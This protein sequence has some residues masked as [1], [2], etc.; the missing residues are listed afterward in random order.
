M[1]SVSILDAD[2]D[3]FFASVEQRDDARLRGRPVIVGPGVVLA[4]SYEAR[5]FGVRSAMGAA[6]A[7][8]LCPDAVVVPARFAAYVEASRAVFAIFDRTAPVV[9]RL[10]I[11]EA[12]LDVRGLE[13]IGGT[14]PQ[15]ARRLRAEVRSEVGLPISVGV[16]STKHLAKV[17]SSAAKPDGLLVIE[18][19]RELAF[20][21]PLPVAR[22]WGVGPST[23]RRL[24]EHGIATVGQL[25]GLP[26]TTVMA[27]L[28][29]AAGSRLHAIAHNR[30]PRRVRAERR[31]RSFGAQSAMRS[32]RDDPAALDA[33]AAALVDRATRRMRAAGRTGRT[34]VLRLRFGDF[35]RATRSRTL[36]HPTA[37]TRPIL[38]TLRA[39][40]AAERDMIARRGITLVG[41]TVANLEPDTASRQLELPLDGR[42]PALL[43]AALD[44]V[45]DR[46]GTAALQRAALLP[47]G[48]RSAPWLFPGEPDD[49]AGDRAAAPWRPFGPDRSLPANTTDAS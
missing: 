39:L 34:V 32:R 20:L 12:F 38:L 30:D 1:S 11:D 23:E 8:R 28:G 42:P 27:I 35:T 15:I 49:P 37:A 36:P 44:A 16:A 13:H 45:R 48:E 31:R 29:R 2:L 18:A 33:V 43:D 17:A 46:F 14:A 41:V 19:G 7:R 21:H 3:A 40:L 26:E 5:A 22:L 4:A 47:A 9:E 25:A 6:R 10:S 24:R